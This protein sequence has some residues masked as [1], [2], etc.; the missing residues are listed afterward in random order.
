[1]ESL[2]RKIMKGMAISESELHRLQRENAILTTQVNELRR[3]F[4]NVRMQTQE[5]RETKYKTTVT[6]STNKKLS[7]STEV[8]RERKEK[9]REAEFQ[10][11]LILQLK[12]RLTELQKT[13]GGGLKFA[14]AGSSS[15][16]QHRQQQYTRKPI[17]PTTQ[18]LP[19][20]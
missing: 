3:E 9:M 18:R 11:D 4:H 6:T 5:V 1:M 8:L 13:F 10:K 12:D 19:P 2:K 15:S 16:P 17:P 20:V 14:L 7:V